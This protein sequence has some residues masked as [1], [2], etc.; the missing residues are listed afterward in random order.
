MPCYRDNQFE[1]ANY[2]RTLS[3][4]I[5]TLS[6]LISRPQIKLKVPTNPLGRVIAANMHY[7]SH[8]LRYLLYPRGGCAALEQPSFVFEPVDEYSAL[9][10]SLLADELVESE[11]DRDEQTQDDIFALLVEISDNEE[12]LNLR[13]KGTG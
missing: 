6:D 13:T 8:R 2:F 3:A 10:W 12:E 9:H 4:K 11:D 7:S 1:L 5:N